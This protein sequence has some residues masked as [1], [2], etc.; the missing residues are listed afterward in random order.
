MKR[1]VRK[2]K[3]G[4]LDLTWFPFSGLI[5]LFLPVPEVVLAHSERVGE[6]RTA[7]GK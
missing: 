4:I 7:Q 5:F 1:L 2:L 6:M 3:V